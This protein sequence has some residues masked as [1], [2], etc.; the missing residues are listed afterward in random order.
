M[1]KSS[2]RVVGC[3]E[4]CSGPASEGVGMKRLAV[5]SVKV[6]FALASALTRPLIR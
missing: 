4:L 5:L 1:K 6:I 2:S 3:V